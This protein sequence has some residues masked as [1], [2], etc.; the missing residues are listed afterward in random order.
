MIIRVAHPFP[1][2]KLI[3]GVNNQIQNSSSSHC[4]HSLWRICFQLIY[5][6]IVS[7]SKGCSIHESSF[8]LKDLYKSQPPAILRH[9]LTVLNFCYYSWRDQTPL[10]L[11]LVLTWLPSGPPWVSQHWH[12]SLLSWLTCTWTWDFLKTWSLPHTHRQMWEVPAVLRFS[13]SPF[14]LL[15]YST[16]LQLCL[17][18]NLVIPGIKELKPFFWIQTEPSFPPSLLWNSYFSL[19]KMMLLF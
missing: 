14:W 2:L 15:L 6:F 1:L 4:F 13:I 18:R 5:P 17:N 9:K 11:S 3:F 7:H 8:S 19:V 12:S 10:L 16:T